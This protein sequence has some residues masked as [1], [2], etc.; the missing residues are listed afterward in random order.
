MTTTLRPTRTTAPL[1][2]ATGAFTALTIAYFAVNA[3]MPHPGDS[4]AA[5]LAYDVAHRG[6]LETGALLMVAAAAPLVVI[7]TL[8]FATL[9]ARLGRVPGI[10]V[11]GAVLAAAALTVSG[12]IGWAGARLTDAAG[13]ALARA[14]ADLSFASG[15]PAYAVGFG[16]FALG[17]AV[18]AL[19]GDLLP[20]PLAWTGV[21]IGIAGAVAVLGLAVPALLPLLPVVRFGGLLWLIVTVV[22]LVRR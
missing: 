7:G 22:T 13:P 8:V 19:I 15:G 14:V 12:I 6:L 1:L 3:R 4:G 9:R 5:V 2:A 17:V 18:P 20:R 21:A 10:A 16:L 11:A